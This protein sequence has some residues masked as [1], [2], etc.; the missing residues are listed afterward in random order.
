MDIFYILGVIGAG[1]LLLGFIFRSHEKYGVGTMP[2][3]WLNFI[4][5]IGLVVYAWTGLV[6]P[7]VVLNTVWGISSGI[8]LGKKYLKI[9]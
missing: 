8:A 6:W 5:C 9:N 2:Y 3:L 7:F 4:G 1:L